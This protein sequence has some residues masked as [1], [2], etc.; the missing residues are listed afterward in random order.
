M[1]DC[2]TLLA[3]R[4]TLAG[5]GSAELVGEHSYHGVGRHPIWMVESSVTGGHAN[6][7]D[8]ALLAGQRGLNGTITA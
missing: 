8:K 7:R 4:D 2:E 6:S 3:G 5:T 1:N